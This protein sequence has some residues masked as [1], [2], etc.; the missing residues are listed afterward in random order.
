MNKHGRRHLAAM[1]LCGALLTACAPARPVVILPPIA[2]TE[3]ADEPVA[4]ELPG[5]ERQLERDQITLVYI[6]A[7]RSAWGD[8]RAKVDGLRAWREGMGD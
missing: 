8:C 7:M 1:I 3:C 2:L 4:P 5:R 6:L